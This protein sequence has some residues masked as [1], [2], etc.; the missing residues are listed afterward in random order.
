VP[1]LSGVLSKESPTTVKDE[2]GRKSRIILYDL[3]EVTRFLHASAYAQVAAKNIQIVHRSIFAG[4]DE[5]NTGDFRKI[6]SDANQSAAG[7]M[8]QFSQRCKTGSPASV[9]NF[10][11]HQRSL[12]L[13]ARRDVDSLFAQVRS[14]NVN[15]EKNFGIA[16]DIAHIVHGGANATFTV[17]SFFAGGGS[18]VLAANGI[19]AADSVVSGQSVIGVVKDEV[20]DQALE[21]VSNEYSAKATKTLMNVVTRDWKYQGALQNAQVR[22][23]GQTGMAV[24]ARTLAFY[25]AY[26]SLKG[27]MAEIS[28]AYEKLTKSQPAEPIVI[29]AVPDLEVPSVR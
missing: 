7:L 17:L 15:L 14:S 11:E 10:L 25:F 6:R 4:G 12:Y 13:A 21:K 27:N 3:H 26:Q 28:D 20:R 5:V 29:K 24:G 2:A 22:L 18:G 19:M 16:S 23:A 8:T 9:H 1:V